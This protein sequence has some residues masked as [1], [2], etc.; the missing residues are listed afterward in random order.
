MKLKIS[1]F[2]SN[3]DGENQDGIILTFDEI[4]SVKYKTR[5]AEYRNFANTDSEVRVRIKG[6]M[7]SVLKGSDDEPLFSGVSSALEEYKNNNFESSTEGLKKEYAGKL[8]F[9]NEKVFQGIEKFDTDNFYEHNKKNIADLTK[10]ALDYKS[11][12][13]YK[14]IIMEINLGNEKTMDLLF[15]NMYVENFEQ[16]FD[17]EKGNGEFLLELKQKY[18]SGNKIRIE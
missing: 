11:S 2:S 13:E 12:S 4:I 1:I 14:N 10:W 15:E 9:L 3:T 18:Y 17:I 8:K 16:E 7:L 6:R 5:T